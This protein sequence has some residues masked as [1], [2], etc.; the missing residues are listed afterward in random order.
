MNFSTTIII[1]WDAA[2]VCQI[3]PIIHISLVALHIDMLISMFSRQFV[4]IQG[5][6]TV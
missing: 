3:L 5:Y 2:V 6:Y 4:P 1:Y